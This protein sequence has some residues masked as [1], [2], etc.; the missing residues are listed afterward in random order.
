M[1]ESREALA[2]VDGGCVCDVA[3]AIDAAGGTADPLR[4]SLETMVE[5]S[6]RDPAQA[7][8][9]LWRLQADWPAL[10]RLEE[11]I[12][13]EPV[14]AAL[15]VGAAIHIARAE[16]ASPTPH[17]RERLPELIELLSGPA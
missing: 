10:Q 4:V 1:R 16:L 11:Q 2:V 8:Q 17:L 15:R 3:G 7:R 13:G 6:E 9:A 5:M 12:G 14:R